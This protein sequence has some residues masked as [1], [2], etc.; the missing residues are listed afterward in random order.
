MTEAATA[1]ETENDS[2]SYPA[3]PFV[4]VGVVVW[5]QGRVLLIRRGKAPR[6]GQWSLPGGAQHLGETVAEAA[7]REVREEAGIDIRVVGLLDV[8][9]LIERDEDGRV[10]HHYA[11]S[12]LVAEAMGDSLTAGDDAAE[13]TWASPADLGR[14]DLW[15]E[16]ARIIALGAER[17]GIAS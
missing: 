12:D 4:G 13:A 11:L 17:L 2:R 8:I 5:H 7:R 6:K 16:T 15:D 9:D 1:D 3:R 10:R 14:Y